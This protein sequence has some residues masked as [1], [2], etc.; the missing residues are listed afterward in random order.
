MIAKRVL[1][2]FA[3]D[4]NECKVQPFGTGLINQTWKIVCADNNYILQRIN[5]HIFLH[6]A[7]IDDNINQVS[8]Y[9]AQHYPDYLFIT[10]V[11]AAGG[12]TLLV[13]EEQEYFRMFPF[14]KDSVSYDVAPTPKVAF[15]AAK[16][17]GKFTRLLTGLPVNLLKF[18][19]PD[20]HNISLRQTQFE[21]AIRNAEPEKLEEAEIC[22]KELMDYR[23]IPERFE[24]IQN[25]PSFRKRI[26]HHDTKISNILFDKRGN[27][28]C[29]IDLDTVMPGYF[30]SDVGDMIR[31][32]VCAVNEE[33]QDFSKIVIR[34]DYFG[35]IVKGYLSEMK[36]ELSI[37]EM[38]HF[39][40]AG[41]FMI[42]M[43]AIRFLTDHLQ[44]DRYYNVSYKGQNLVRAMNQATL[45][46]KLNEKTPLFEAM[47]K[48][49]THAAV[50]P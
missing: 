11:A 16:Q 28:L 19:L 23:F 12:Q 46:R 34:D 38:D 13:T 8:N 29:V 42:Y 36:D 15:E 10:P 2:Q 33:E 26:T 24:A 4:T 6:P 32:Y 25:D 20:F 50:M 22:I 14:I 45:L 17:F 43:Q 30:I 31:T 9:L 3:I 35:A 1:A 47:V 21:E 39:V 37:T 48:Q 7:D 27:G 49:C 5:H 44:N 18:T 41:L 40:Y